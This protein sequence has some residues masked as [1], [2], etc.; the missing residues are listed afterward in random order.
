MQI[1]SIAS[2]I[3]EME[4]VPVHFNDTKTFSSITYLKPNTNKTPPFVSFV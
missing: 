4:K 2:K 1:T 3:I